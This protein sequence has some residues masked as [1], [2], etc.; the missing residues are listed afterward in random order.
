MKVDSLLASPERN[1]DE[2]LRVGKEFGLAT[3][4]TSLLVLE[5]LEQ[6]LDHGIEPPKSRAK[7]FAEWNAKIE[8]RKTKTA[9]SK[10]ER[11]A[12]VVRQMERAREV[13]GEGVQGPARTS[14]T[15]TGRRR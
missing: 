15:R 9:K 10:E 1:Y 3:P 13:V 2:L 6:Y 4:A 11:L 12:V 5:T 7:I 14:C 8:D